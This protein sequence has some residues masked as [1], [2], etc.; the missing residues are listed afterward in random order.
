LRIGFPVYDRMGAQRIA[1]IG[2]KAGIQLVD[3]ITNMIL[4]K[5]YDESGWEMEN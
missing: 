5:Y 2:Y 3:I 4:E 1:M